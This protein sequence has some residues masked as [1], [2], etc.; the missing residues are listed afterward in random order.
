MIYSTNN[1]S[2]QLVGY[3]E[4]DWAGDVNTRKSTSEYA[5]QI[6]GST[7]SWMSKCQS[8]VALSTIEAEYVALSTATQE[9]IWLHALL[10]GMGFAQKSPTTIFD[11]QE[12]I[13]LTKNPIRQPRHYHLRRDT[14]DIL[15]N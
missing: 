9:A 6:G 10:K 3:D 8:I 5:F 7:I 11:N 12:T 4:A 14:T 1:N 2:T 13:V 15:F